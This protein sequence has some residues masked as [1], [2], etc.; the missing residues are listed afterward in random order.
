MEKANPEG[1]QPQSRIEFRSNTVLRWPK[2]LDLALRA[3]FAFVRCD[4]HVPCCFDATGSPIRDKIVITLLLQ[5]R[6][7]PSHP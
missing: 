5:Y 2:G 6:S 7:W 3:Q 4:P 1:L